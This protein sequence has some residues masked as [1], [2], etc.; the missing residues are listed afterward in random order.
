MR[1]TNDERRKCIITQLLTDA[2]GACKWYLAEDT[3]SDEIKLALGRFQC[4]SLTS[5]P[6][7]FR[8]TSPRLRIICTW[9]LYAADNQPRTCCCRMAP[10]AVPATL[11]RVLGSAE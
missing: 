7:S 9:L 6:L 5:R 11:A 8:P 1:T 4:P 10:A 2:S 3:A